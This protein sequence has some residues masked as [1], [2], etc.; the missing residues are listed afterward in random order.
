M[1][2]MG[3]K[4]TM[5]AVLISTVA[6]CEGLV[7]DELPFSDSDSLG[8]TNPE[9]NRSYRIVDTGVQK[10]FNTS[11]EIAAPQQ[12]EAF[13][14]QDAQFDG[15]QAS[16]RDNGDGSITDLVTGLMWTKTP[17][18]NG[19]GS[20][21]AADKLTYSEALIYAQSVGVGG[22]SDW[23]VPSIK[24][25]YS[26][27][28]FSG[29]DPNAQLT[30]SAG[31]RPFIN[32]DYF[33]FGYGDLAAGDRII[34]AQMATSTIYTGLTMGGNETLF[35]YNFA[36]GRIK[37]YPAGTL[38]NGQTKGYYVYFVRGAE[39]YGLND[40][41]DNQ[42][43]T[44][45]DEATGLMW[46]QDDSKS[47]MSWKDALAWVDQKNEEEYLGYSD[48]RLPNIKELQSI[49]DYSRSPQST[50]SPAIDPIFNCTEIV[51]ESGSRNY[52]F[53]WS[54]TTHVNMQGGGSACYIAFGDALGFLE[55]PPRSGQ[56]NLT[57]VHGAGAQ[58]SDPK[59]GDPADYPMGHGP[60][61][62]VIRIYNLV[63]CVRTI[64]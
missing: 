8:I 50:N 18:L 25:L 46:S 13:Y 5:L 43:G 45:S 17:D 21:D 2:T 41:K 27:T 53:Y 11:Q 61:G 57:D 3:L 35:G 14:G 20:I 49:V 47:G 9:G 52:G 40:F 19:D 12:G 39:D 23:R 7:P 24:E 28:D 42:D 32:T 34:D 4:I 29:V 59:A 30:S 51:D 22:Y 55:M 16:Y 15:N 44:I 33:D 56:Y 10:F 63:R 62:D 64:K 48:W 6:A 38:P 1:K 54:G 31:L 26:L 60:Q 36:D 58:R 37:G